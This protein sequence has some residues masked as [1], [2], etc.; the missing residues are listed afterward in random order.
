MPLLTTGAGVYRAIGG[1]GAFDMTTLPIYIN[2]SIANTCYQERTGSP[3]TTLCASGDVC[4][5]IKNLGTAGGYF[6]ATT[7]GQ[8]GIYTVAGGLTY[9]QSDDVDDGYDF[10]G[11]SQTGIDWIAVTTRIPSGP[12]SGTFMSIFGKGFQTDT[13]TFRTVYDGASNQSFNPNSNSLGIAAGDYTVN[14]VTNPTSP[15]FAFDTPIL[16]ECVATCASP[17]LNQ[18]WRSSFS[19]NRQG[20][21]RIYGFVW[22]TAGVP[23]GGDISSIRTQLGALGGLSL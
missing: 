1:G 21:G 13:S 20:R 9:I 7:D 15:V 4:G 18:M 5:S 23:A 17:E 10:D 12:G 2:P 19:T 16:A 6:R 11:A 14:G 3:P 8:R 22:A